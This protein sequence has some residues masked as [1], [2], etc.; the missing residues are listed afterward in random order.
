VHLRELQ[1]GLGA[2]T[3]GQRGVSDYVAEGLSIA[4]RISNFFHGI[5]MNSLGGKDIEKMQVKDAVPFR[6]I[7]FE[8]LTLSVITDNTDV[9]EASNVELLGAEL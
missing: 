1:L 8:N 4:T 7:L 3:L 2:D 6:L 5:K 9:D